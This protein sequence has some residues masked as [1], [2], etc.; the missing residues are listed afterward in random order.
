MSSHMSE[1]YVVRPGDYTK[2]ES[3]LLKGGLDDFLFAAFITYIATFVF[4][5]P[6]RYLLSLINLQNML[7]L[8]DLIYFLSTGLLFFRAILVR[9][10][11]NMGIATI[12]LILLIHF[13]IGTLNGL[14]LF[15][16]L[17]AVKMF[18]PLLYGCAVWPIIQTRFDLLQRWIRFFFV[19]TIFALVLQKILGPMFWE[20]QAFETAFGVTHT[21]REW[22]ADG[23]RRLAGFSRTSFDAAVV[24]GLGGLSTLILTQNLISRILVCCT[25]LIAI[26]WT[27]TKGMLVTFLLA[28]CWFMFTS[29]RYRISTGRLLMSALCIITI[30]LPVAVVFFELGDPGR[31]KSA[32]FML[33]SL[34]DRFSWMWPNAVGLFT[35]PIHYLTGLGLGSIGTAQSFGPSYFRL[36]AGDN[37]FVYC[38]VNFGAMAAIYLAFPAVNSWFIKLDANPLNIWR[39][40]TLIMAF[41]YGLTTNVIEQA[42][43]CS[44]L[45]LCYGA[46]FSSLSG[47]TARDTVT[48]LDGRL[49]P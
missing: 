42:V 13:I 12:S 20:N 43:F 10:H 40:G 8:R 23:Q 44:M 38:Y 36:N 22:W 48:L 6:L 27:T 32:P 18:F 29:L 19:A 34:W 26:Y 45:G 14:A 49:T 21:S 17:F 5:A 28:A 4:E 47:A 25:A 31:V 7:Y 39:V 46:A 15:P 35:Q 1:S 33:S 9:K 37:I 24:L 3:S 41:G 30:A 11:I 2:I 16:Q